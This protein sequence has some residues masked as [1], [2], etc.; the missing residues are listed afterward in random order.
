MVSIPSGLIRPSLKILTLALLT[1]GALSSPSEPKPIT[2]S[3]AVLDSLTGDST[4]V[5]G[6]VVYVDFWAS[7][8]VPCR[9]SFPWMTELLARYKGQ[10]LQIVTINLDRDRAAAQKFLDA[11]GASLP[12][13][14]DSAGRF[15]KLYDL[16]V[17]PTSLLYGRDGDLRS[18]H[19]GFDENKTAMIESQIKKL[20]QEKSTK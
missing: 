3:L 9:K 6:N 14:Y 10:G 12:V 17:M 5:E 7:W 11:T 4:I 20:I 1:W 8:C 15:A 16:Q 2:A 19:D 18:R 13:V